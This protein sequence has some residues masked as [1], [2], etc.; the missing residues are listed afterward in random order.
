M[1]KLGTIS[2]QANDSTDVFLVMQ[3]RE[4]GIEQS[5]EA[6]MNIIGTQFDSDSAW[7]TGNIPRMK[8]VQV[9][10]DTSIIQAWFKGEEFQGSFMITVYLECE[11]TEELIEAEADETEE[12]FDN[13][14]DLEPQEINL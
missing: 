7:V 1:D 2:F 6:L 8:S 11:L 13:K 3:V 10:G 5:D 9:E 12:G 4:D 14:E